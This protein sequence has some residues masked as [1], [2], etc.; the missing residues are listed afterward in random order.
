[1]KLSCLW[2]RGW[3]LGRALP[4]ARQAFSA[5]PPSLLPAP[6]LTVPATAPPPAS[7]G[8]NPSSD[9][10]KELRY[11]EAAFTG[12]IPEPPARFTFCRLPWTRRGTS[13]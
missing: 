2:D 3:W 5:Q 7:P 10:A 8:G 11:A 6:V 9:R 12:Y 13:L 1:M 4:C